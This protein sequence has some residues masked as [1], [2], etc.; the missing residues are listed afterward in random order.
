[1]SANQPPPPE[2]SIVLPVYNEGERVE[3]VLRALHAGVRTPK[4]LVVVWDFDA[5]TTRPVVRI[6][7]A[8]EVRDRLR[9]DSFRFAADKPPQQFVLLDVRG[10]LDY[11]APGHVPGAVNLGSHV[12]ADSLEAIL[13][14]HWP[15]ID[16]TKVPMVIYC[17]GP[18]CIRSRIC[19]TLAARG[20][21]LRLEWFRGG[22]EEW[23]RL[24][25]RLAP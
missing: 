18:D 3:P 12:F 10:P 5:D 24:G 7:T 17:Y 20:G 22:I 15:G 16:R 2:L 6:V 19:S 1:M 14:K 4:E 23:R 8:E 21:F 11:G 13:A 9:A 25:E